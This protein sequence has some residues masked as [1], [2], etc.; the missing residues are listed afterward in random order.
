MTEQT[1]AELTKQLEIAN[2]KNLQ[3]ISKIEYDKIH[4]I[5][6]WVYFAT[7]EQYA[8]DNHYK[9]GKTTTSLKTRLGPYQ[10]GRPDEMYY[11]FEYETEHVALLENIIREL[12]KEYRQ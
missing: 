3:L 7:T 6:G 4:K 8:K 5:D 9:F 1:I 12:L 10:V 2:D 11:V